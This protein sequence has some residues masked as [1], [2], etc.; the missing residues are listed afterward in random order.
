MSL[1]VVVLHSQLSTDLI[2]IELLCYDARL[3]PLMTVILYLKLELTWSSKVC[4][5]V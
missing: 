5:T 4:K 1:N 2:D 3:Y